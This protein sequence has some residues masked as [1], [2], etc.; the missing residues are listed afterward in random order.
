MPMLVFLCEQRTQFCTAVEPFVTGQHP[1]PAHWRTFL[2]ALR[3]KLTL[4]N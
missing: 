4:R 1:I 3:A 2:K